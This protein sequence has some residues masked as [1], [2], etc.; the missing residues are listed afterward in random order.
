[1]VELAHK[2]A[3]DGPPLVV[4]HGLFGS[5]SN[6]RGIARQLEPHYQV[7]LVDLRNH[8]GSPQAPGMSY[9]ELAN[10]VLGL[11]DRLGFAHFHLLGHSM[12]GK[13]AMRFALDHP[14]R[15]HSLMV[16]DI[17]PTASPSDHNPVI[18]A[19]KALPVEQCSTRAEADAH[20]AQH[21]DEP[22]LRAFLLQNLVSQPGGAG[23]AWRIG[24]S[25]IEAALPDLYGFPLAA[26]AQQFPGPTLFVHGSLSEYLGPAHLADIRV[27]FPAAE[28]EGIEGAGHWLHA[29]K[30]A[31]FLAIV[32][33]FLARCPGA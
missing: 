5:S 22:G 6:W 9:P 27:L 14:G 23:F 33:D 17:A 25:H 16:A 10:D 20:L 30:P 29:E 19:L 32:K 11:V 12:G 21:I 1:M 13:T 3:G 18:D 26:T 2:L 4:L 15:L 8:G 7:C 31:E 24:L 28:L